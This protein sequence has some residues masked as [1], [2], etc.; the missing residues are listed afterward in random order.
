MALP[1][2]ECVEAMPQIDKLKAIYCAVR[3][4]AGEPD[5]LPHCGCVNVVN[6]LLDNIYCGLLIWAET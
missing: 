1:T 2:C 6:D 4:L 3:G 5:T